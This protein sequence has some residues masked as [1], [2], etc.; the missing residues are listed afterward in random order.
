V[1]PAKNTARKGNR[2]ESQSVGIFQD[3][4]WVAA[5]RRHIGGAGDLLLVWGQ[6]PYVIRD[7]QR[8]R[9]MLHID[10][11]QKGCV[12]VLAEVKATQGAYTAFKRPDRRALVHYA[13]QHNLLPI[14]VWWKPRARTHEI[15]HVG[16]WPAS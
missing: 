6:E 15:I 3:E 7:G 4:G 16:A 13:A 1:T 9:S 8:R 11:V 14:L 10:M 5:S 2:K 12:G